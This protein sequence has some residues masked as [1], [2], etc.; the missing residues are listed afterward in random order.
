MLGF[1]VR[2][3]RCVWV[4]FGSLLTA[5][6]GVSGEAPAPPP[7]PVPKNLQV[8]PKDIK[9]ER[10]IAEMDGFV[11][12]LGVGCDYCHAPAKLPPGVAPPPGDNLDFSLDVKPT[13]LATRQM[14]MMVRTINS[15]V[16]AAVGKAPDKA[17]HI[18]CMN[19]HRGMVTPPLPI[20]DVLDQTVAAKGRSAAVAQYREL[21]TKYYGSQIYDF[22][23]GEMP[24]TNPATTF[25]LGGL[26]AYALK[27]IQAGKTEDAVA[28]L[29]LNLEY[30]PKSAQSWALI[31][32]AYQGRN[33][34]GAALDAAQ[35]SLAL[36]P[37]NPA[38]KGLVEQIKAMP[39]QQAPPPAKK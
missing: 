38:A 23:D 1:N 11:A 29:K 3:V 37:G 32:F 39:V 34:R 35:K 16:P 15:M 6:P 33:D 18:Q 19:C 25:R 12:A 9:V 31:A 7:L 21:R 20:G 13:K 17:V 5:L 30:Y 4:I 36:A 10:L 8:F 28:W 27:L 22:S 2:P 14:L 24:V 26:Q